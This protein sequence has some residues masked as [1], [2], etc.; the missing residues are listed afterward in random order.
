MKVTRIAYSAHLNPGKY[1]VL[2]KQARRLGRVRSEVWQRYGSIGGV[3]SG[4]RDRQVRDRWLADGTHALFGVLANAWKETVRDAIG[5]IAA[6]LA[7]AK[8]DVRRAISRRTNDPDGRKRMFGALKADEWAGC[9]TGP[10]ATGP[11]CRSRTPA[12]HQPSGE[13]T[14]RTA[15]P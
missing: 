10:I 11:D 8:V 6:N 12:R 13:R 14:I 5:D 1:A 9:R 4:L 3:G 7:A 2:V 15:Q